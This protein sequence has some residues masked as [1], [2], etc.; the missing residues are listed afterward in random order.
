[1]SFYSLKYVN[2]THAAPWSNHYSGRDKETCLDQETRTMDIRQVE[3]CPLVRESKL[4]IFGSNR[5]VFV[6]CRVGERM[7][8]T[9]TQ[10]N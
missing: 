5:S 6:R 9:Q 2:S 8:Q 10:P 4:E 3:I 1:M 7:T